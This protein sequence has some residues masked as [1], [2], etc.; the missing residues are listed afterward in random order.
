[1][2]TDRTPDDG[3]ART[4]RAKPAP[5]DRVV[6]EALAPYIDVPK[7]RRLAAAGADLQEALHDG[8]SPAEVQ[9]LLN[10]LA[11]PLTP[12]EREPVRSPA[13]A[14]AFLMLRLGHLDQEHLC[15]LCLNTKHR[16]QKLHT[17]YVGSV[18]TSMIRTGEVFKEALRRGWPAAGCG[19]DR[20][21]D[22]RGGPLV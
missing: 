13:D 14:A 10:T 15:V 9:A 11:I 6:R 1:M 12:A 5:P 21:P 4:P 18:D 17:V 22:R 3:R 16:I 20:P 8:E 19:C 2:T 7:L